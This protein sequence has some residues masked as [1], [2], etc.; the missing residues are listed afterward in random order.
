MAGELRDEVGGERVREIS[1][2]KALEREAEAVFDKYFTPANKKILNKALRMS[3]WEL[4][5]GK[6]RKSDFAKL[7]DKFVSH[8]AHNLQGGIIG[9]GTGIQS[10]TEKREEWKKAREAVLEYVDEL[11]DDL[12]GDSEIAAAIQNAAEE[13]GLEDVSLSNE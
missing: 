7:K 12:V 4:K 13:A 5:V 9:H 3:M 1:D 8:A 10:I 11:D 2:K 6:G